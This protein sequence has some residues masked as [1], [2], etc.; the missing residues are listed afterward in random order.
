MKRPSEIR[1]QDPLSEVTRAERK[2]LLGVSAIGIVIARS[3]LVPARISALGIEFDRTDQR[4]LLGMLAAVVAYFLVAFVVYG[5]SDLVA[6]RLAFRNAIMD[7][8]RQ[9]DG[10]SP[11][12]RESEDRLRNR[13]A[14]S[15]R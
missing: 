13:L 11:E 1:V 6:W 8:Q 2:S 3:G 15:G 9:Y 7:S 5:I 4:A 14:A 10:Q 12:Q